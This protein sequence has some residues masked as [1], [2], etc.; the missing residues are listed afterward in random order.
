M[1]KVRAFVAITIDKKIKDTV[2]ELQNT[3]KKSNADVKWVEPKNL[4][5]TL[6]FLGNIDEERLPE[7][8]RAIDDSVSNISPFKIS[9][10]GLGVFPGSGKPRV[11]WIGIKEGKKQYI[12]LHE[13]LSSTLGQALLLNYKDHKKDKISPHL[14]MGRVR[15]KEGQDR[16]LTAF[17]KNQSFY[18]GEMKVEE[19]HLIKSTLTSTGPLYIT[20]K[21]F[22]F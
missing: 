21:T 16:L 6:Q 4:H 8:Y 17:K 11:L 2:N 5:L 9:F 3:L 20:L 18:G 15:S 14:T 1:S 13:E 22:P 7:Y 10:A 12:R 19:L